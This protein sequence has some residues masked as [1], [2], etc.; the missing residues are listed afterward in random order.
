MV[1]S[2]DEKESNAAE[3]GQKGEAKTRRRSSP[4]KSPAKRESSPAKKG[5]K[6]EEKQ[7]IGSK[8][9]G[10]VDRKG[11]PVDMG[12]FASSMRGLANPLSV[13]AA[14]KEPPSRRRRATRRGKSRAPQCLRGM[15]ATM[16]GGDV[17]LRLCQLVDV[18]PSCQHLYVMAPDAPHW[19]EIDN[20]QTLQDAGVTVGADLLLIE[21]EPDEDEL[22]RALNK[23]SKPRAPEDGFNNTRLFGGTRRPAAG[24]PSVAAD[25]V[26]GDES[27]PLEE[28]PAADASESGEAGEAAA[29][30]DSGDAQKA[31]P[32][33]TS[34][35][36]TVTVHAQPRLARGRMANIGVYLASKRS[37]PATRAA[38]QSAANGSAARNRM[39]GRCTLLNEA[40]AHECSACEAPLV[41][42]PDSGKRKQRSAS[43]SP[44]RKLRKQ[45][46]SE[47][48]SENNGVEWTSSRSSAFRDARKPVRSATRH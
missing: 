42:S 37:S 46:D 38:G 34:D 15:A 16:S 17:K 40:T 20:E 31:T 9:V 26:A 13:D 33:H 7:A 3:N 8:I 41:A 32:A 47:S 35:A 48:E 10:L 19:C 24:A 25:D 14:S 22:Q 4:K 36:D 30:A 18:S 5:R 45:S 27:A 23:S 1:L 44:E 39:C 6:K 2:I 29:A 28:P 12:E 43:P 11:A 21:G